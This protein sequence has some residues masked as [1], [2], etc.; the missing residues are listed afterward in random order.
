MKD[1][2]RGV[3]GKFQVTRTDGQ[4]EPGQK[5]ENCEYFVLDLTHDPHALAAIQAYARSCE[6]HY[7]ALSIDLENAAHR[8]KKRAAGHEVDCILQ[9]E[10]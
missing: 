1:K 3:Y 9:M 6:P 2:Q 10:S 4:S 8:M 5:H 7:P